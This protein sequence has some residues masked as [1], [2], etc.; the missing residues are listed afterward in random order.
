MDKTV[1][2]PFMYHISSKKTGLELLA[3][4]VFL[5]DNE[6]NGL[7][8]GEFGFVVCGNVLLNGIA[9]SVKHTAYLGINAKTVSS[10]VTRH[11]EEMLSGFGTDAADKEWFTEGLKL[12]TEGRIKGSINERLDE[13]I[14]CGTNLY[15]H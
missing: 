11:F 4:V 3:E 2:A 15:I 14:E 7:L 9:I 6:D 13:H 10:M 5:A 8:D 1:L 12:M